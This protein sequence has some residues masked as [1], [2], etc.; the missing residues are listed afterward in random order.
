MAVASVTP[1]EIGTSMLRRRALSAWA[2]DRKNGR[3][4]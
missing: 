3:P 4:E 2:A 1:S